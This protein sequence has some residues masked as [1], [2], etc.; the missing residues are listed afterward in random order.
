MSKGRVEV[1]ISARGNH[2]EFNRQLGQSTP[3]ENGSKSFC[4]TIL[5]RTVQKT[6]PPEFRNHL[7]RVHAVEAVAH[8]IEPW[9]ERGR[10][11]DAP[12]TGRIEP[13]TLIKTEEPAMVLVDPLGA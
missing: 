8:F 6:K 12:E 9:A 11:Y 2:D 10:G 13:D 3:F 7:R 5:G 1:R 4:V